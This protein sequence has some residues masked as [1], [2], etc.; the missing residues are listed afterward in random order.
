MMRHGSLV[1]ATAVALSVTAVVRGTR[2]HVVDYSRQVFTAFAIDIEQGA[3]SG[4][5]EIAIERWST[6][7]ERQKLLQA[8]HHYEQGELLNVLRG[9][10]EVGHIR[11]PMALRYPLRVAI[12]TPMEEGGRRILVATDRPISFAEFW[13]QPRTMDYPFLVAELRLKPDDTGEGR[14]SSPAQVRRVGDTILVDEFAAQPVRLEQ[15]R[16]ER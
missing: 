10:D 14:L 11:T 15:V 12:E 9:L 5:L 2:A 1:M 13:H 16:R 4:R 8:M 6:E 7:A 3:R